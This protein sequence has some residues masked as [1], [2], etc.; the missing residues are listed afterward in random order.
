MTFQRSKRS[1]SKSVTLTGVVALLTA[2]VA[3]PACTTEEVSEETSDTTDE[4]TE[5]SE[6]T[7]EN[8]SVGQLTDELS[9]YLGETVTVRQ[10]VQELVGDSAFLL[11][12]DQFFGGEEVLVI[13]AS[14]EGLMLV[15]GEGTEVQVTGEVRE[16]L[17][18]DLEQEYDV[19]LD[20]DLF[21]EYEQQPVIVAQSL[22]LAPDPEDISENPG[23]YYN[24][25]LAVNAEVEQFWSADVMT[26]DSEGLF[27]E[28]DLL[29]LNP[30]ATLDFQQDEEVVMTGVLR[31]FIATEIEQEYDLTWDLDLQQEIEAEYQERPVFIADE[32]YPSAL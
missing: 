3:L 1:L 31:P 23:E 21:A 25:R 11:D 16:F 10:D 30:S 4:T 5:V 6:A 14:E 8:V 22:A 20:P 18:A 27:D 9:A 17:M 28:N 29:V 12:D 26:V 15:E 32:V 19:E 2:M 13:N 24:R 7:Q